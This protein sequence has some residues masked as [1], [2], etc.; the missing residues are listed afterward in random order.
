MR[1]DADRILRDA[2]VILTGL[3]AAAADCV[4]QQAAL[5]YAAVIVAA[6]VG[7]LAGEVETARQRRHAIQQRILAD[8]PVRVMH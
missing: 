5:A 8:L 4:R 2:D 3:P 6:R 7:Y 1:R